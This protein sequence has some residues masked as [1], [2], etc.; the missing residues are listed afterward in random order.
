MPLSFA[1]TDKKNVASTTNSNFS[2]V[3]R[4]HVCF[5]DTGIRLT[6]Q[7]TCIKPIR[8]PQDRDSNEAREKREQALFLFS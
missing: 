6:T 7:A 5:R 4:G 8:N 3:L 2:L 1:K